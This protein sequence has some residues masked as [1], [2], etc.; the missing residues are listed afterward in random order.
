VNALAAQLTP[1]LKSCLKSKPL[2]LVDAWG[3]GDIQEGST[4]NS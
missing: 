2:G 4:R 3:H 1:L